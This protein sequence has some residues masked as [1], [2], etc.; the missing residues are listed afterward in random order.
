MD[1]KD[2]AV[3]P[4]RRLGLHS[5]D[6]VHASFNVGDGEAKILA[7]FGPAVGDGFETVDVSAEAPWNA[8]RR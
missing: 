3:S 1:R 8:M 4:A 2:Q 6:T 5:A 7:I